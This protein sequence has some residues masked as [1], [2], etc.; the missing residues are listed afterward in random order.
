MAAQ[1]SLG[2]PKKAPKTRLKSSKGCKK[3]DS[4]MEPILATFWTHFGQLLELILVLKSAP[5]GDQRW[6][7]FW[8]PLAQALRGLALT[9]SGIIREVWKG[10]WNWN[11]T[12][13]RRGR[14]IYKVKLA[15]LRLCNLVP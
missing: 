13:Q 11:Y 1:D 5:E 6:D 12:L 10:Y 9:F 14:D 8:E 2:R 15:A 7:H 4:K 3:V